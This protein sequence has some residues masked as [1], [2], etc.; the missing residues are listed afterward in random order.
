MIKRARAVNY[1]DYIRLPIPDLLLFPINRTG[2]IRET[3]G[4]KENRAQAESR[5]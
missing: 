4:S 3:A 2:D 5:Y 1:P